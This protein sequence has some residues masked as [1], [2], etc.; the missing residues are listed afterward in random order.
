MT[1]IMHNILHK[2]PL[3]GVVDITKSALF[4]ELHKE[5]P[6]YSKLMNTFLPGQYFTHCGSGSRIDYF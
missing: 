5:E 6:V 2:D 3:L 4:D 1:T